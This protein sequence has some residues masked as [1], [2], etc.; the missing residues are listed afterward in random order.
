[1]GQQRRRRK[2]KSNKGRKKEVSIGEERQRKYMNVL[3]LG[4]DNRKV[5]KTT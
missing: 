5:E 3:V 1:V 4:Q 2:K